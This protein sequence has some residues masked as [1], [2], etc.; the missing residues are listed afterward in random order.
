MI[1]HRR[2]DHISDVITAH[3]RLHG[4]TNNLAIINRRAAGVAR[5]DRRIDLRRQKSKTAV[6]IE[7]HLVAG[8][9]SLRDGDDRTAERISKYRDLVEQSRKS[10][11]RERFCPLKKLFIFHSQNCKI[12]LVPDRLYKRSVFFR[13]TAFFEL[14]KNR[15]CHHMSVGHDP[16]SSDDK[17]GTYGAFS[18]AVL[19]RLA[20]ARFAV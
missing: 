19:P 16:V 5:V 2:R 9:H 7:G 13:V 3:D 8:N 12:T 18:G 20:I 17:T 10:A 14:Y 4:N 6:C 11:K 15:I 1:Y